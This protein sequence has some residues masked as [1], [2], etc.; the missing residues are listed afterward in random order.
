MSHYLIRDSSVSFMG[1][2]PLIRRSRAKNKICATLPPVVGGPVY[3]FRPLSTAAG[4]LRRRC[5]RS[6]EAAG[7]AAPVVRPKQQRTA[8][9]GWPTGIGSAS[10]RG[11]RSGTTT[12][13]PHHHHGPV[14]WLDPFPAKLS[15]P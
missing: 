1:G 11:R 5:S 8:P 12:S 7:P 3:G 4:R 10:A 13:G 14:V 15:Y 2:L 6:R 9:V